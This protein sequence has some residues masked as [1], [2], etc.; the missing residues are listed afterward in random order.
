MT[1]PVVTVSL[2]RYQVHAAP[3]YKKLGKVVDDEHKS[4][5]WAKPWWRAMQELLFRIKCL[6][7][8]IFLRYDA[9]L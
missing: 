9:V 2:P 4:T 5:S 6:T 1:V 8:Y 7:I 3:D